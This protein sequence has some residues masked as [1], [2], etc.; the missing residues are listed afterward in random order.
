[1]ENL[2][3]KT[4]KSPTDTELAAPSPTETKSSGKRDFLNEE[5]IL[6][7]LALWE[8]GLKRSKTPRVADNEFGRVHERMLEIGRALSN[9]GASYDS[10]RCAACHRVFSDSVRVKTTIP[11]YDY[12]S[13]R[14]INWYA[15]SATC[16]AKLV[17]RQREE[18]AKRHGLPPSFLKPART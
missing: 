11:H 17:D 8:A 6:E 9:W 13:E 12:T 7:A 2:A 16:A 3:G 5:G 18:E 15:C 14:Y 10:Q 1:M 4:L